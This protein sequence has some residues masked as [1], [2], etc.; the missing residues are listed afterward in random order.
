MVLSIE[1]LR[2]VQIVVLAAALPLSVIAARGYWHAPF[3]TVLRPLPLVTLGFIVA[4]SVRFLS[5]GPDASLL[6]QGLA[7]TVTV[8]AV[9][10][11]SLQF[12]LV[13]TERKVL[14]S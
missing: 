6:I 5:L 11:A 14:G 4:L 7:W 8:A 1:L 3:G 10:W 2:L 13:T 12:V 9:C